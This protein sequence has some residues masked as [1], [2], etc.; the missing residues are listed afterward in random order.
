MSK[1]LEELDDVMRDIE[2]LN[3]IGDKGQLDGEC[4]EY[5]T[6]EVGYQQL[7]NDFIV[8]ALLP[9]SY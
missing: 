2:Q 7:A 5:L 4:D 3:A 8:K 6:C 9:Q 1:I